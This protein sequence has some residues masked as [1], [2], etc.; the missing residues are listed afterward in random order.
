MLI[1]HF[2]LSKCIVVCHLISLSTRMAAVHRVKLP[3]YGRYYINI[4]IDIDFDIDIDIH[5]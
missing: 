1:V 4:D 2:Q 5:M 3:I